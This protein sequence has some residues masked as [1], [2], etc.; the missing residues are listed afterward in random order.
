MNVLT[1]ART[2]APRWT[3]VM[4]MYGDVPDAEEFNKALEREL[5]KVFALLEKGYRSLDKQLR[6][7]IN[8]QEE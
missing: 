6:R 5:K 2:A 4:E 3:G 1:T 8:E 7:Y